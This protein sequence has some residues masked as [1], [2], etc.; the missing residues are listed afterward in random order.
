LVDLENDSLSATVLAHNISNT[1]PHTVTVAAMYCVLQDIIAQ[2]NKE[3]RFECQDRSFSMMFEKIMVI[4]SEIPQSLDAIFRAATSRVT[5]IPDGN[6]AV[7]RA[8][9]ERFDAAIVISTGEEMDLAETVL[10]LRDISGSMK[11]I[12]VSDR[13]NTVKSAVPYETL[14]SLVSNAT[15]MTTRELEKHL[16]WF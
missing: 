16:N 4:G 13:A 8:Q 10:N 9:H 7:S 2:A 12:I 5:H 1:W 15:V 3:I 6:M 11:L 14:A